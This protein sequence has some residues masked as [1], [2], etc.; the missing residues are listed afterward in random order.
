MESHGPRPRND[1]PS[2]LA[3]LLALALCWQLY[4]PGLTGPFVLDDAP[5]MH[6]LA[7]AVKNASADEGLLE[8]ITRGEAGPTGRP[9]SLASLYLDALSGL[10]Q[11][12]RFKRTNILIHL[13]NATLIALL[14]QLLTSAYTNKTRTGWIAV[15]AAVI[16]MLHPLSVSTVLYVVQRMTLLMTTFSLC[17]LTGYLYGRQLLASRPALGYALMS[18]SILVFGS[19]A[20]LSKENGALVPLY[21]LAI[22]LTIPN[23]R[24]AHRNAPAAQWRFLFLYTPLLL[25]IA[26]VLA[27]WGSFSRSY[28]LREFDLA[29]R[30]TTE[31]RVIADYIR[32]IFLP[33]L[34]DGSVFHDDYPILSPDG[35]TIF[36]AAA[37]GALFALAVHLRRKQPLF[38][39]A[40]LWF[41]VGHSMESTVLPLELYFE[42]R[43][44]LPMS[45]PL[46]ASVVYA[47]SLLRPYP[48]LKMIT[49]VSVI[50]GV[51]LL[52]HQQ[53]TLW[54]D[55]DL[56]AEV[57]ARN[58]PYSVRAQ[59]FLA[60]NLAEQ[61][62]YRSA[63]RIIRRIHTR[64]PENAGL[65]AQLAQLSCL[66]GEHS[67]RY[68]E[69]LVTAAPDT[70]YDNAL[71]T[72]LVVLSDM[73]KPNGCYEG[74]RDLLI[75]AV[76]ALRNNPAYQLP[77]T[78][79]T[80]YYLEGGIW[81]N[82]GRLNEAM[83][84]LDKA[85]EMNPDPNIPLLQATW[86][87]TAGLPDAA[88]RYVDQAELAA[89]SRVWSSRR[90][91]T[92]IARIRER[93]ASPEVPPPGV[94]PA[95]G[96]DGY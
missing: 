50:T 21:C 7:E 24:S 58:H 87:A 44:Y 28:E 15:T 83:H 19:L 91:L 29:Q 6:P 56:L 66:S 68:L 8:Y 22:E 94:G 4:S 43:N 32:A 59:Q 31:F 23:T 51:A 79:G 25:L 65:I 27:E 35:R 54:G 52:L 61:G 30:L 46:L 13:L 69:Q 38:S 90:E 12:T 42:H 34:R 63:A 48:A 80:I 2:G 81:A 39:L 71:L 40:V 84:A 1:L 55:R 85:F 9:V 77:G 3:L 96:A 57:S 88:S 86:L 47:G 49:G 93:V 89:R 33:S 10:D 72:T 92:N 45:V 67:P 74:N 18:A 82:E 14:F 17:A 16:W 70:V 60:S 75:E 64:H 73:S 36:Y 41:T 76:A 11:A 78:L 26:G 53:T 5:N 37:Y 95:P 20:V 62:D